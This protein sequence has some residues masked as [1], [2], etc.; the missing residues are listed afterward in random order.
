MEIIYNIKD[1]IGFAATDVAE[2][3]EI[4][5]KYFTIGGL[6]AD[7]TVKDNWVIVKFDDNEMKRQMHNLKPLPNCAE[8][9]N[10]I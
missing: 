7:V 3:K 10:S 6:S 9:E 4:L 8:R 1:L 2:L 5:V